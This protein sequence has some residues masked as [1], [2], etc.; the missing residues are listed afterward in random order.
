LRIEFLCRGWQSFKARIVYKK[1][2]KPHVR[3]FFLF[4][5]MMEVITYS[6]LKHNIESCITKGQFPLGIPA[7]RDR[8]CQQALKNRL[9]PIFEPTFNDCC[10]RYR[11]KH[12]AHDAMPKIYRE[13]MAGCKWIVDMDLSKFSEAFTTNH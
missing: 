1:L 13:I 8:T 6:V 2:F 12:S 9:E 3:G 4:G 10:Y 11:P 7:I 5:K